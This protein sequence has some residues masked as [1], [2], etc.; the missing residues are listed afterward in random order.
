MYKTIAKITGII[1]AGY[2]MANTLTFSD[3]YDSKMR[4]LQDIQISCRNFED[5]KKGW[6]LASIIFNL[7]YK[8]EIDNVLVECGKKK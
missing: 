6:G 8:N 2:L 1:A 7:N 5:I 4:N 3:N